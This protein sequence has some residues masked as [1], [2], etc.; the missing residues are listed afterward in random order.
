MSC[1]RIVD[2]HGDIV[3]ENYPKSPGYYYFMIR[4][5]SFI[6]KQLLQYHIVEFTKFH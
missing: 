3:I 2:P 6:S 1:I 5:H 4:L